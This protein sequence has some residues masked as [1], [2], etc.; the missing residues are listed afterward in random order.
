MTLDTDC[1][2]F[3][4]RAERLLADAADA[5]SPAAHT[6]DRVGDDE[7][8]AAGY[9]L[10]TA[11]VTVLFAERDG[12]PSVLM[13]RRAAHIGKHRTEWAFPGGIVEPS[14]DSVLD[15]ALRE[16]EEELGIATRHI[17]VWCGL[18][19]VIT[20]TGFEVHPFA[21]RLASDATFAPNP[22]EVDR[23]DFIPLSALAD[24]ELRR[25]ITFVGDGGER[26][27]DAI[28]HDGK[29]IWG[30]SARIIGRFAPVLAAAVHSADGTA[31]RGADPT[32]AP[33][34]AT[35]T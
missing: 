12:A 2:A 4:A 15:A 14:D 30:A 19:P 25:T 28:A 20:G 11:A 29:V 10:R 7:R 9:Q 21:G 13:I 32:D 3:F 8:R 23:F 33:V 31:S 26:R 16:T 22:D 34:A 5:A 18:S 35:A 27:W 17:Q 24:P 1:A 6:V